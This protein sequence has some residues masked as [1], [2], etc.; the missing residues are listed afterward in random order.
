MLKYI[1]FGMALVMAIFALYLYHERH[2]PA[3]RVFGIVLAYISGAIA[4]KL[5]F[6]ISPP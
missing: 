4:L 2:K 1:L 6:M 3:V 5:F